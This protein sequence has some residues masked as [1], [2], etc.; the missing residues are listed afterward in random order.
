LQESCARHSGLFAESMTIG[1]A[2]DN[3]REERRYHREPGIYSQ[4]FNFRLYAIALHQDF[5]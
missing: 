3:R 2:L 4:I 1:D 5:N